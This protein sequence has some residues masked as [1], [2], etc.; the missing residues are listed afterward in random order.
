MFDKKKQQDDE[1]IEMTNHIL[2]FV[3]GWSSDVE[4]RV[5]HCGIKRY[6]IS[7]R[8]ES[9]LKSKNKFQEQKQKR[10]FVKERRRKQR[11]EKMH[12]NTLQVGG[13]KMR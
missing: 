3:K 13:G 10:F 2:M 1:N 7:K 8:Q 5:I 9:V 12:W 11:G 4:E 6:F